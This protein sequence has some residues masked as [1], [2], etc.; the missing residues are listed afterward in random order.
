[1]V[2]IFFEVGLIGKRGVMFMMN[3]ICIAFSC[4]WYILPIILPAPAVARVVD[5]PSLIKSPLTEPRD[6]MHKFGYSGLKSGELSLKNINDPDFIGRPLSGGRVEPKQFIKDCGAE[7]SAS[8]STAATVSGAIA[9]PSNE[10]SKKNTSGNWLEVGYEKFSGFIHGGL[11]GGGMMA[12]MLWVNGVWGTG[13][14]NVK[15]SGAALLRRPT[16]MQG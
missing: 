7:S 11:L 10:A 9:K 5:S 13:K 8:S 2:N 14:P 1:M 15:L 3:S 12:Y 16:R 4:A 6:V